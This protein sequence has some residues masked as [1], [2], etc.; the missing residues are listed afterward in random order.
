M[1]GEGRGGEG[2]VGVGGE[3]GISLRLKTAKMWLRVTRGHGPSLAG[4]QGCFAPAQEHWGRCDWAG[5][6]GGQV[7]GLAVSP[8]GWGQGSGAV[9]THTRQCCGHSMRGRIEALLCSIW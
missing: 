4:L 5:R 2:S 3:V 7:E 1:R 6:K 9:K 8:V